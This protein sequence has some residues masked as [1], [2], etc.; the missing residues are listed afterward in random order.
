MDTFS[1]TPDHQGFLV[2]VRHENG[3]RTF[4]RFATDEEATAWIVE[5]RR[6]AAATSRLN[7]A[8]RLAAKDIASAELRE[9]RS[10]GSAPA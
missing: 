8:E 3:G 4:H 9:L 2:E 5:R 6:T 10:A 7:T 1:L